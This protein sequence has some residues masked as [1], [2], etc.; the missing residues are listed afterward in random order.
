VRQ[1]KARHVAVADWLGERKERK[2]MDR[3]VTECEGV[4]SMGHMN[5][6]HTNQKHKKKEKMAHTRRKEIKAE[7]NHPSS[8][9]L[10]VKGHPFAAM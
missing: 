4:A 10:C 6:W 2:M 3:D 9:H 1:R 8:G 7:G 5:V